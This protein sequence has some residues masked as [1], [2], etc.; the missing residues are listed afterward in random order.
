MRIECTKKGAHAGSVN[1]GMEMLV[2]AQYDVSESDAAYLIAT[3]KAKA[4]GKRGRPPKGG[5]DV[6]AA[7]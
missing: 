7:A 4:V 3:G 1:D 2:G 6:E 5:T